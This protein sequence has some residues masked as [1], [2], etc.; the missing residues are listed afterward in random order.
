MANVHESVNVTLW[1]QTQRNF[2]RRVAGIVCF[3]LITRRLLKAIELQGICN[4]V[5][6]RDLDSFL[7]RFVSFIYSEEK[8]RPESHYTGRPEVP[9]E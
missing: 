3:Q 4:D 6:V 1:E 2:I 8:V 9:L 5:F 7:Y